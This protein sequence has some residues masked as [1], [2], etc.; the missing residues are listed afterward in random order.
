MLSREEALKWCTKHLVE[1]PEVKPS[2]APDGWKWD[3]ISLKPKLVLF[4]RY[5]N[6]FILSV[7]Y[8]RYKP[9]KTITNFKDIKLKPFDHRC[10]SAVDPSMITKSYRNQFAVSSFSFKYLMKNVHKMARP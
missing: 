3:D 4:S 10:R 2:I 9:R 1:W 8:D 7:H 6:G 5:E